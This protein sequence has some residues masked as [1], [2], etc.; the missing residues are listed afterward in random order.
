MLDDELEFIGTHFSSFDER[1]SFSKL[2]GQSSAGV[3]EFDR[4]IMQINYVKNKVAGTL[5]GL[6]FQVGAFAESK[7]IHCIRGSVWDVLVD[8]RTESPTFKEWFGMTLSASQKNFMKVPPGFAHGYITL[9]DETEL[10]YFS[11]QELSLEHE[12]G[13]VWNDT[14]IN[15]KWPMKPTLL[16]FK[17]QNWPKFS[18]VEL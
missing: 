11:D 7:I 8:V 10:I 6:H 9:E 16:S 1:G 12:R 14:S 2:F 4:K 17:D 13:I 15:V 3:M 5:R 18:E